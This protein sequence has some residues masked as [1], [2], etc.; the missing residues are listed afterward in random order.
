MIHRKT[1]N[2]FYEYYFPSRSKTR[3]YY[4]LFCRSSGAWCC[5]C[6]ARNFNFKLD[7]CRHVKILKWYLKHHPKMIID[8]PN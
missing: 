7:E 1:I 5:D 6:L 4:V 2:G 8:L 3:Q